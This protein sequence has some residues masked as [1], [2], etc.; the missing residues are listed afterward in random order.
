MTGKNHKMMHDLVT[1]IYYSIF[2][3]DFVP[4]ILV[5]FTL[6]LTF[7]Y[8]H[9]FGDQHKIVENIQQ[10]E[11]R[12]RIDPAKALAQNVKFVMRMKRQM[13]RFKARKEEEQ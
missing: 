8:F 10:D 1:F 3:E 6:I 13:K 2:N 4:I 5:V 12:V 7:I 9:F 11:V